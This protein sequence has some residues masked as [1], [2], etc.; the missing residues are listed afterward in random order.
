MKNSIKA[1]G[2]KLSEP[3]GG[4]YP[5]EDNNQ[6]CLNNHRALTSK[7]KQAI[8]QS[9]KAVSPNIRDT[10]MMLFLRF[11]Q[12]NITN[13]DFFPAFRELDIDQ[14]GSSIVLRAHATTVM[15]TFMS[16][17]DNLENPGR[18]HQLL[19]STAR[20]HRGRGVHLQQYK[21]MFETFLELMEEMIGEDFRGIARLSWQHLAD[22]ALDVIR[23]AFEGNGNIP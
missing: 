15:Q 2:G 19:A 5:Y 13:K 1:M 11:F 14:L 17:V 8:R 9:W 12:K 7:E 16:L 23:T 3:Q 22:I 4:G 21:D 18:F 6:N 10:G 20:N